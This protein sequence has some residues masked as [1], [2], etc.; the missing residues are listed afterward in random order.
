MF[1]RDKLTVSEYPTVKKILGYYYLS[2]AN[3]YSLPVVCVRALKISCCS[4]LLSLSDDM[5][6]EDL[7]IFA[8]QMGPR[9]ESGR[10]LFFNWRMYGWRDFAVSGKGY[11][12]I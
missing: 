11:E 4:V 6:S 3:G 7:S 9:E 8:V 10:S 12:V 1:P 5:Q 2:V